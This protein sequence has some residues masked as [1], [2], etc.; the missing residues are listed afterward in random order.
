LALLYWSKISL[1]MQILSL[2]QNYEVVSELKE[3]GKMAKEITVDW[4]LTLLEFRVKFEKNYGTSLSSA[5][6]SS[7]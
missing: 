2:W 7:R 3:F 4:R 5:P 1:R 6:A